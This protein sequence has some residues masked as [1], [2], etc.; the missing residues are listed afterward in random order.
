MQVFEGALRPTWPGIPPGLL[1]PSPATLPSLLGSLFPALLALLLQCLFFFR[2]FLRR[3]VFGLL[4][5]CLDISATLYYE[6]LPISKPYL[7]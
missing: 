3:L 7:S 6:E 5:F 4:P 1:A 2:L